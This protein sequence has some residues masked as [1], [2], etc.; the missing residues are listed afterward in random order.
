MKLPAFVITKR[1]IKIDKSKG[2]SL[3]SDLQ[4]L[5][6]LFRGMPCKIFLT[7]GVAMSLYAGKIYRYHHDF[8]TGIFS[9]DLETV[10]VHLKKKG[11]RLVKRVMMTHLSPRMDLQV[12]KDFDTARLS[13]YPHGALR[14]RA[15]KKGRSFK[16]FRN[17]SHFFDIF[18]WKKTDE[19]VYPVGYRKPIPWEDFYPDK[20]IDKDSSIYLPNINH[21]KHLSPTTSK[22]QEDYDQAGML[23]IDN[24][25]IKREKKKIN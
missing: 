5:T 9:E 19:G 24:P 7:G 3:E 17:R 20:A 15:L 18:L 11:Y 2:S 14:I 4:E 8:D 6:E 23:T 16:I 25:K 13:Q 21:K 12:V 22:Q 1:N 10:A